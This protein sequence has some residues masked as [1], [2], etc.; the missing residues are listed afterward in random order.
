MAI[1]INHKDNSLQ[2]DEVTAPENPPAGTVVLFVNASGKLSIKNNAGTVSIAGALIDD[3]APELGADLNVGAFAITGTPPA[4]LTS[5]GGDLILESGDGG[6]TSGVVGDIILTPGIDA[7]N[8]PGNINLVPKA[9]ANATPGIRFFELP[10]NG[11]NY[12]QLRAQSALGGDYT[13]FL[14]IEN[15]NDVGSQ[16]ITTN[17]GGNLSFT[18]VLVGHLAVDTKVADYTLLI[19]DDG[20]MI[21]M[22]SGSNFTITIP[23]NASVAFPIGTQILFERLG[24][25]TLTIDIAVGD[26]LESAGALRDLASQYSTATII[27]TAAT[28]WVL[29]GD[30]A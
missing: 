2:F 20:K 29:A 23:L 10:A 27:K 16:F 21:Q 19:S 5:D 14:P 6:A 15:P 22:N 26:V 12:T 4:T 8:A 7:T 28:R 24:S 17:T 30:L 18:D 13:W 25:G 11:A 9:G 1:R 3:P